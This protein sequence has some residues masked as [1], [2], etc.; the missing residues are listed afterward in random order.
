MKYLLGLLVGFEILDGVMSHFLIRGGLAREGNP[1]LLPLVGE[2]NFLIIK[3]VGVF[4][5]ALILWDIYKRFPKLAVIT[6]S[7]FVTFYGGLVLWN[8]S[9][10]LLA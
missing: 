6:T 5:C 7:I 2:I 9:L 1:F 3:V 4:I 8:S 10:F